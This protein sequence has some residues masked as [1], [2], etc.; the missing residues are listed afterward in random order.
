MQMADSTIF[1]I[2]HMEN[3]SILPGFSVATVKHD[4]NQVR[5][6][7]TWFCQGRIAWF[8]PEKSSRRIACLILRSF[9]CTVNQNDIV[10]FWFSRLRQTSAEQIK[11]GIMLGYAWGKIKSSLSGLDFLRL[12]S[13]RHHSNTSY[14]CTLGIKSRGHCVFFDLKYT[15]L[16]QCKQI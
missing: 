11:R 1:E 10:S 9:L 7:R 4:Q 16:M 5:K 13:Y 8:R 12:N 14:S 15:E 6:L 3:M 2:Q